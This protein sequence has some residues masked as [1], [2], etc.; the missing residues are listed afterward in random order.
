MGGTSPHK[1]KIWSAGE[2]W[3]ARPVIFPV[4]CEDFV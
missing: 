1:E 2:L 3:N 4:M